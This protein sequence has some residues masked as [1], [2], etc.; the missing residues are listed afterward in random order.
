[1]IKGL[2]KERAVL[3]NRELLQGSLGSCEV[4]A[5]LFSVLQPRK[6]NFAIEIPIFFCLSFSLSGPG[7]SFPLSFDDKFRRGLEQR[8]N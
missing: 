5:T 2:A 3:I 1:M 7:I 6:L 4:G 8:F